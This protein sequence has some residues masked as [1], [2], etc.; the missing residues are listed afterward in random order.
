[1]Q[2]RGDGRGG[3]FSLPMHETNFIFKQP[4]YTDGNFLFKAGCLG[5]KDDISDRK[6]ST[7]GHFLFGKRHYEQ[8]KMLKQR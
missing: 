3:T 7:Q 2:E 4:Y 1:M 8:M 6:V 5:G